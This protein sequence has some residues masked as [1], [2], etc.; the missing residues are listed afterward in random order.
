MITNKKA[1]MKGLKF[2]KN[3]SEDFEKIARKVEKNLHTGLL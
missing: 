3:I 1:H 2:K